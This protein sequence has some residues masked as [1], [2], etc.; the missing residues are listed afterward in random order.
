LVRFETPVTARGSC[1]NLC[2]FPC[3]GMRLW[4]M[5]C[6]YLPGNPHA[7]RPHPRES[8][9]AARRPCGTYARG[10]TTR[11]PPQPPFNLRTVGIYGAIESSARAGATPRLPRRGPRADRFTTAQ[12][13]ARACAKRRWAH[14]RRKGV[15][16]P[17]PCLK[18]AVANRLQALSSACT[19]IQRGVVCWAV[20]FIRSHGFVL[21][22]GF[23]VHHAST[24]KPKFH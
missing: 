15:G 10:P 23:R 6:L 9:P 4:Q 2:Q 8:P 18:G 14:R 17:E 16:A 24:P 13:C 12:A 3:A 20:V 19:A 21:R 7:N 5:P 22:L 11:P 1:H